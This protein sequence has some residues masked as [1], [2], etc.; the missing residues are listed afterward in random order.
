MGL[1]VVISGAIM[2]VALM[3]VLYS[4][5][6]LMSS[7]TSVSETSSEIS[8]LENEILQTEISLDTLIAN[9]SM[10]SLTFNVNNIN[11]EKLW[12][13]ENFDVIV[14]YDADISGTKTRITETLPY[15]PLSY[16]YTILAE[17]VSTTA[18]TAT[19]VYTDIV[20]L[21][22]TANVV[23][24]DSVVLFHT[25]VSFEDAAGSDCSARIALFIDGVMVAE[26][27]DYSDD[28]SPEMPGNVGLTWWEDNLAAGAHDFDVRWL[29]QQVDCQIEQTTERS[30]QV[31]EFRP[32]NGVP[33]IIHQATS[34]TNESYPNTDTPVSGIRGNPIIDGPDSLILTTGTVTFEDDSSNTA[35]CKMGIFIDDTLQAEQFAFI[36]DDNEASSIGLMWGETG[37]SAGSHPIEFQARESI[38]GCETDTAMQR[39]MQIVEYTSGDPTILAEETSTALQ[40][41]TGVYTLIT[42]LEDTV[43]VQG[44]GSLILFTATV[45]FDADAPDAEGDAALFIDG[46]M[47][48]E[49]RTMIDAGSNEP[50]HVNLHWW[51]TGLSAGNHD[52]EVR[53]KEGQ[54]GAETDTETQSHMQVME[55]TCTKQWNLASI[56]NDVLDPGILNPEETARVSVELCNPIFLNGSS[57]SLIFEFISLPSVS[58]HSFPSIHPSIHS[59]IYLF[60]HS[61]IHP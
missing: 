58:L 11:N 5:P 24:P 35:S 17:V 21:T 27:E 52:F 39:H 7:I 1:S 25:N 42:T 49:G 8:K 44:P 33:T 29:E 53:G 18:D 38:A 15:V 9:S 6:T 34:T 22:A 10:P 55:F 61:F 31:I 50:G 60:V 54:A 13:Y 36:Q 47:V 16:N 30:M 32:G 51:T 43:A 20:D 40:A 23:G 48:A 28:N 57:V 12:D 4:I 2:M 3:F 41:M 45:T 37:L 26:A 19:G 14:T 46:N 56:L 59:F